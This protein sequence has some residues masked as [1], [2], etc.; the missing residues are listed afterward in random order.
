MLIKVYKTNL[1]RK[2]F[3]NHF[4]CNS[5]MNLLGHSEPVEL[6]NNYCNFP[7]EFYF[8][9][10]EVWHLNGLFRRVDTYSNGL[11][12]YRPVEGNKDDDLAIVNID[13][14]H[15]PWGKLDLCWEDEAWVIG[16]TISLSY[17]Y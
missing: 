6:V 12:I 17:F 1:V 13:K 8:C 5:S 7:E 11:P 9:N 16:E 3:G 14:F 4:F 15:N 2:N 10:D